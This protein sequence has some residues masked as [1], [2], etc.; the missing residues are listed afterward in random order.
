MSP[1]AKSESMQLKAKIISE[2]TNVLGE[3]KERS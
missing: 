2:F 3:I 1:Q